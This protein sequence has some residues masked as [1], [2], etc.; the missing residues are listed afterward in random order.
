MKACFSGPPESSKRGP[1]ED[2]ELEDYPQDS[3]R[4][5]RMLD[6][7]IPIWRTALAVS[8]FPV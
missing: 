2:G 4:T 7:I 8:T 3:N 5:L 1:I 6:N